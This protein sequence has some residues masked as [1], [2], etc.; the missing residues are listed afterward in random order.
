MA[1][2]KNINL[3]IIG[4]LFSLCNTASPVNAQLPDHYREKVIQT[5]TRD[6]GTF[7]GRSNTGA[8]QKYVKYWNARSDFK[9]GLQSAYC[10][11]ALDYWYK[12]AGVNPNIYLTPRA[13]NWQKYCKN[14]VAIWS[15]TPAE[16]AGLREAGA[17][18]YQSSHGNHVGLYLQYEDFSFITIEANTSTARSIIKYNKTGEGVFRLKTP[19]N[20]KSLRP[21]YYCDTIKQATEWTGK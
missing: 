8:V 13:I 21:L 19:I 12:Q 3:Q 5:A 2:G 6:V 9:L 7:E 1:T 11:L 16:L 15:A 17:L 18:V 4:I 10:G 20:N 14:P